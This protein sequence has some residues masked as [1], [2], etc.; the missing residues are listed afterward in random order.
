MCMDFIYHLRGN[1]SESLLKVLLST[2]LISCFA[3]STQPNSPGSKERIS[4]YSVNR[5]QTAAWF[6]FLPDHLSRPEKSSCW[7]SN[8]FLCSTVILVCWIPCIS[9]N[10]SRVLGVSF[11]WGTT[12]AVTTWKTLTPLAIVMGGSHQVF[13]YHYYSFDHHT[14]A[15]GKWVH[16]TLS[17]IESSH[18]CCFPGAG[19]SFG[20]VLFWMKKHPLLPS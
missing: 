5:A 16:H 15:R 20:H 8:F 1:P 9:S 3:K 11:T 2:T 6:L 13:H 18:A 19:F 12:F 4:W 14:Q 7:R 17:G 10:F